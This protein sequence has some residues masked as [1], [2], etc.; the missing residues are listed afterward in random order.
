M[1]WPAAAIGAAVSGGFGLMGSLLSSHSAHA[2]NRAN[3]GMMREQRDWEERMAN[4]EVTRRVADLKAAGLNPMLAIN[5]GGA[6]STPNVAPAR[7]ENE[8]EGAGADFSRA[9]SNAVEVA[10]ASSAIRKQEAEIETQK[11]LTRKV[12]AEASVAESEVPYSAVN[13]KYRS[14]IVTR[15][16]IRLG[17]EIDNMGIDYDTKRFDLD[18]M[19]PLVAE[20]QRILNMAAEAGIPE[21]EATKEFY[22][23]VPYAKW[24][25]IIRQVLGIGS[26]KIGPR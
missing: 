19:K 26:V 18:K 25:G 6:A 16:M 7:V 23:K 8:W 9:A 17:Q 20:Y 24:I 14:E 10:L 11:A 21:L 5:G 15:Q 13:A 3:I 1:A 4:T 2:A 12:G 22:E